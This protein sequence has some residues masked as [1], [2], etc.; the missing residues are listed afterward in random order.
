MAYDVTQIYAIVN[1]AA[2]DAL[3]KNAGVTKLDTT[4]FV[5]LGK[6]LSEYG[7]LD[8]W[9]SALAKRISKTVIFA[10]TYDAKRRSVLRDEMEWGA[11]IQKVYYKMPSAGANDTW[12]DKPVASGDDA[13]KYKQASPYDVDESIEVKSVIFGNKGTWSI[14]IVRPLIQIKN[15][16][17]NEQS[18][19]AFIDGIYV[20]IDNALKLEEERLEALAV[21]T[22]IAL[23]ISRGCA[24]NVLNLYNAAHDDAPITV[25]EALTNAEFIRMWSKAMS[26]TIDQMK[27]IS[28][29]YSPYEWETFT[30][31]EK[32]VVEVLAQA[33]S[34][35][36]VYLQADT[37]HNELTRLNDRGGSF[38]KIS[39]WQSSGKGY[40][41]ADVSKIDI[42]NDG[43]QEEGV[44]AAKRVTQG[45]I[46][47]FVHD[48][49]AVACSFYDR[50]T[51]E[52]VNPRAEVLIHGDKA[53]KGYAVDGNANAFVFY[54][55]NAGTITVS[56][57][58]GATLK[59][60]HVYSG[61]ENTITVSNGK[62]PTS[63]DVTLTQ[64]GTSTTY[65]FVPTTNADVAITVS[66]A[67]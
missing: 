42:E 27:N 21:N 54:A 6:S 5:S 61:I 53:E 8:G 29:V 57:D 41:F 11:F 14:E 48:I 7:L 47:A 67:T 63:S 3:G 64:V 34:A 39:F 66:D 45:G 44:Y 18:M 50:R 55:E 36:D 46:L 24:L 20:T 30:P 25:D 32:L 59:Y 4:N 31:D 65:K 40:A 13:G 12:V 10:R 9:F 23:A 26:D 51:W 17:L 62:V 2:N 16:F 58:A 38:E 28:T 19:F 43:L 60:N 22:G 15:A 49:E 52:M 37:F 33:A 35:A 56:G 1:D